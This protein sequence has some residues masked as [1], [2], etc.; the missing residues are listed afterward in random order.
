M[1]VR[2]FPQLKSIIEQN[3]FKGQE[4][5]VTSFLVTFLTVAP[6]NF[7][8]HLPLTIPKSTAQVI[9]TNGTEVFSVTHG[10]GEGALPNPFLESKLKVKATT[11]NI[12]T[13]REIVEKYDSIIKISSKQIIKKKRKMIL[14]RISLRS[15]FLPI[16]SENFRFPAFDTFNNLHG[17]IIR[18]VRPW[19]GP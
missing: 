8:L 6:V 9:S 13:I 1:F 5:E 15:L 16:M 4:K 17:G 18:A 19:K 14:L 3:A 10:G 2:T 12:N 11:R 7:P